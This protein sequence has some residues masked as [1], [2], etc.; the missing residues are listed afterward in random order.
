MAGISDFQVHTEQYYMHIDPSN[1]VLATTT[2][3]GRFHDWIDGVTIPVVWKRRW[4]KGRVFYCSLG[5][6][7]ADFEVLET[8][9]IIRRGL[10]WATRQGL[11]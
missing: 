3:N 11:E 10:L 1:E 4:G 8:R 6:V 5:H 2:F 7:A 9:E